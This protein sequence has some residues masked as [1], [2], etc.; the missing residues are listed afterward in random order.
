LKLIEDA[1]NAGHPGA[2]YAL[3]TWYLHGCVLSRDEN[4]GIKL[5]LGAANHLEPNALYDAAIA[6]EEGRLTRMDRAKAFDMYLKAALLGEKQSIF[7]I[8]RMLFHGIG[9][10]K[11]KRIAQVF[12]ELAAKLGIE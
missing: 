1:A 9:V 12:L 10:R 2:Q 7:E 4:K 5:I 11:N 8:G 6:Y 3:G